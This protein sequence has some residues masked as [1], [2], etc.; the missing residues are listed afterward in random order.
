MV[1]VKICGLSRKCDI[2]FVNVEKPEYIG[3]VFADSQR[4]VTPEQAFELRKHLVQEIIPVG[5]FVNE[6][7]ENILLLIQK[8]VID[9]VQL[10]G[11]ED[12]N[13]IKRL[14]EL[15][16]KPVIKAISVQNFGDVQK[17]ESTTADYLLLDN[18]SGGTGQ[19]F[20]WRLIGETQKPYILAGGLDAS[21]VVQAINETAPFAVDVSSGVETDGFKDPIK[22]KKFIR[23]VK[24]GQ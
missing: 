1:K 22:I 3:F 10:H 5:V 2:D 9:I 13:Y 11:N 18:Q 7:I 15:T 6:A 23:M 4:K 19:T 8:G 16:D 17:W 20:D 24:C 14:K 12:E 21:N